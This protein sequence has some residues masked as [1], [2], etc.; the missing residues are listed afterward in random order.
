MKNTRNLDDI[1]R[2]GTGIAFILF[3]LLFI[4]AFA[5]HPDLL[6]PHM[7]SLQET[8]L[9]AHNNSFLAFGHVLVLFDAGILIVVVLHLMKALD[10]PSGSAAW[11]GFIGAV[12][13]VLGAIMLAAE[14][15]AECLTISAVDSVT[16]LQF[17]QAMPALIA[18]FSKAGWMVLTWGVVLLAIGLTLQA[19]GL[20]KTKLIPPWRSILLLGIWL[21]GFPDG[22]EIYALIGSFMIA[23]ALIPY[24]VHLIRNKHRNES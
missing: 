2:I 16:Q 18:I 19:I 14:K 6:N 9:R 1:K 8:I 20:L 13:A 10:S 22:E 24:G 12:T 7:L 23:V 17:T 3:P 21:L 11:A 5:V 15:G 4:F